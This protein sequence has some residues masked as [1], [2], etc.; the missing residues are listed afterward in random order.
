MSGSNGLKGLIHND[1]FAVSYCPKTS[2]VVPLRVKT[3]VL[4]R[5]SG[6][7][8]GQ[9]QECFTFWRNFQKVPCFLTGG[10][11]KKQSDVFK[12]SDGSHN[13]A[14]GLYLEVKN[15]GRSQVW[16]Y[17]TKIN[18]KRKCFGLE[19]AFAVR[20]QQAQNLANEYRSKIAL[21]IDPKPKKI[22]VGASSHLVKD[23]YFEAMGNRRVTQ[24]S[25]GNSL[26]T[27]LQKLHWASTRE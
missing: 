19:S 18:G 9:G 10:I 15:N 17:F 27:N 11:A 12:L 16:L 7:G 22:D 13:V 21:G 23:V 24:N 1:F 6:A 26:A 8:K 3:F 4:F 2:K 25:K 14:R 20:L 5:I